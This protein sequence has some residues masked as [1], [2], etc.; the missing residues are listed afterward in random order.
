MFRTNVPTVAEVMKQLKSFRRHYDAET[1]Q[2][3]KFDQNSVV[4]YSFDDPKVYI[5][6]KTGDQVHNDNSFV[7]LIMG[8]FG[9]GKT[10]WALTEI[11]KRAC[12][13]PCWHNGRRRSR[14]ALVR[15]TS[16]ELVSTTLATWLSWFGDLG[17]IKSHQKPI[18][19]YEHTF[20]DGNGIVELELLFLALDRPD[21]V[22][23]LKSLELTG[24]YFNEVSEIPEMA[25][26]VMSGR[27]NRYPSKAF[28]DE[29]YWSGIICDSNPVDIDHWMYK[30]FVEQEVTGYSIFKQPPGLIKDE[31]ND[32]VNNPDAD[33]IQNLPENYY[34]NLALGQTQEF[35]NVYCLGEWGTVSDN[36]RVFTEFNSDIHAR[37]SVDAIQGEPLYL[38]VDFGLTPSVVV[39]QRTAR[40]QVLIL[41][42]YCGEDIGIRNF[43]ESIVLPD[44][45]LLFPYCHIGDIVECDPA[46]NARSDILETMSAIGELIELG[47]N[48]TPAQTNDLEPR[49]A[50]VRFFLDKM[51]DGMP[52]LILDRKR[53]PTLYKGFL[54]D[55]YYRRLAVAGEARYQEKPFK[56]F[57][58]HP[59][60]ALQYILLA[61]ASEI[62]V[63][64]KTKSIDFS[65]FH[66]P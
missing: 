6:S 48:A 59:M 1:H 54:K 56:N 25:L 62:V 40:G 19:T 57:A 3:L 15:N 2:H 24:A 7:R 13:V 21:D 53:C 66:N 47:L 65:Q 26:A 37:D 22:K 42:E 41:K 10:T 38:G 36:K 35:I 14:W 52:A 5:P 43:M 49:L 64:N 55:Y 17:D 4:I 34:T 45:K 23:K 27:V 28:C 9:S 61:F 46:G 33:N 16:G 32:W 20:N 29:P 31:N 8:P 44:I 18:L 60:D 12:E 30:R 39:V 11:V 63:K 51:I 50:A 58:S